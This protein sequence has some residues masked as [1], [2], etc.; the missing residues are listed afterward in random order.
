MLEPNALKSSL[1]KEMRKGVRTYNNE[2]RQH[3]EH[4]SGKQYLKPAELILSAYIFPMSPMPMIPTDI[5]SIFV[6]LMFGN[7]LSVVYILQV[8]TP[9]VEL[10]ETQRQNPT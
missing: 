7:H 1:K 2:D 3:G 8:Q 4:H 5:C 10:Q 6:T 9:M